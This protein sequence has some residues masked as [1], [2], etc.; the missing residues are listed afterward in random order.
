MRVNAMRRGFEAGWL[1]LLSSAGCSVDSRAVSVEAQQPAAASNAA[2]AS[3]A[4]STT[5]PLPPMTGGGGTSNMGASSIVIPSSVSVPVNPAT[6]AGGSAGAGSYRLTVTRIGSGSGKITSTPPGI[7]CGDTCS[8]EFDAQVLLRAGTENGQDSFF[9]G[10]SSSDP[11][12][13]G[14]KQVC[15]LDHELALTADFEPM[16]HNLMFVSS[17]TYFSNLGGVAAYD[18]ECNGLATAAGINDAA[19]SA[20]VVAMTDVASATQPFGNLIERLGTARGWVRMDGLPVADDAASLFAP[21]RYY[22]PRFS[23]QGQLANA[24]S[25]RLWTGMGD[26]PGDH[27]SGWTVAREGSV[28]GIGM[29]DSITWWSVGFATCN[30]EQLP[31]ACLGKT[32]TQP[33]SAPPAHQGKRLWLTTSP[34]L[35]GSGRPDEKCQSERPAGVERGVALIAYSTK[36]PSTVIDPAATYVLSDGRLVGTGAELLAGGMTV[37]VW[38]S[39]D[40]SIPN[41]SP[42][43]WTGT[44]SITALGTLESTC[45]DWTSADP[46]LNGTLAVATNSSFGAYGIPTSCAVSMYLNC[47]EP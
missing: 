38:L 5:L 47:V 18:A 9:A 31:I 11:D 22:P 14:P 8:A 6:G 16:A 39:A 7:D 17:K 34:Y 13:N 12:C 46:T 10:W 36:P 42:N 35:P 44:S 15:L 41:N 1:A 4:S 21:L 45:L 19:G 27:C 25:I 43:V 3:G 32:K 28:V 37:G 23:E 20:F 24:G 33:V 40:G 29:S 30:I 26:D 2:G